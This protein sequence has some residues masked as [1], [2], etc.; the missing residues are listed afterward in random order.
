MNL[1][2][3][4]RRPSVVIGG[5][6]VGASAPP[7]VVAEL[8]ANHNGSLERALAHVREAKR[9]GADA[10]KFQ[11]YTPDTLTIDCAAD[12]FTIRQGPWNGTTL[13]ELYQRA[14]T[15][16]EWHD[17]LFAEARKLDLIV[18]STAFDT[19]SVDLLERLDTAA[20][21]VASFEACDLALLARIARTKRPVILSTGLTSLAE[22][23]EAVET[24]RTG[25]CDQIVL[26]HCVSAYPAPASA[27]NLLTLSHLAEAFNVPVGLS[28]HTM[29]TAVACAAVALGACLIEKHFILDRRDG[30]PDA[31]FSIEPAELAQLATGCQMAWAAR[32]HVSYSRDA[33]EEPNVVFRRSIYAVR[34]IEEGELLTSENIRVIRPGYGLPPRFLPQVLGRRAGRQLRRGDRIQWDVLR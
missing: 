7:M 34:D 4:D 31:M 6:T 22:I 2:M 32:G 16:W 1:Q 21:K 33:S 30:G 3:S 8:S 26:L 14:Y 20:I 28:D 18:F 29:G 9:C 15:P 12:D 27:A 25:G 11:T 5:R 19:T 13:H 24:L 23:A 17:A 10:I